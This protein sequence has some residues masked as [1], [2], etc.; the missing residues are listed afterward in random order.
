MPMLVTDPTIDGNP[1]IYANPSF[2][3]LSGYAMDEILGQTCLILF[4]AGTDEATAARIR[5]AME[6]H[7]RLVEEVRMH[8]KDGTPMWVA[9]FLAPVVV[10]G[11]VVQHFASLLDISRRVEAEAEVRRI[12]ADLDRRVRDRTRALGQTNARLE[13]EVERRTAVEAMLRDALARQEEDTRYR[14]FLAREIEHRTRNTLQFAASILGFQS[15]TSTDGTVREALRSA[16][17]RLIR[18]ARMQS[19][20][21]RG[22]QAG[23]LDF[24]AHLD[25]L[26]RE[27]LDATDRGGGQIA[28]EVR[29]ASVVLGPDAVLPLGLIVGEAIVNAVKH[30]F[31][32]GAR[33]RIRIELRPLGTGMMSLSVEDD[34][35]GFAGPRRA[36]SMGLDL[37]G[38]LASKVKGQTGIEPQPG[39]GTRVSVVF[40][41][42][43][44]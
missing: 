29:A 10:D 37:I 32:D 42:A 27:V 26:A 22:E 34:G 43:G 12:Y 15:T 25:E 6:T 36:G 31:P 9:L 4:G 17:D 39:G 44:A 19:R 11:R 41:V 18:M 24:G 38:A 33:G 23:S 40:P 1:I 28:L 30:A 35:V 13:E 8:R 16:Q 7:E 21:Y 20:M 2:L 14:A 5:S 3:A